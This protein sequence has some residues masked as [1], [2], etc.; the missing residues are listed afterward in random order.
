MAKPNFQGSRGQDGKGSG[1]DRSFVES[2]LHTLD[3][4]ASGIAALAGA[5]S[6]GLGQPFVAAVDLIREA[7]GRVIVTGMGNRATSGARSRRRWRR[8]GRRRFLSTP[9]KPVMAIS[10]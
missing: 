2:A 4:E 10:A 9:A 6:D 5:I 8:P 1:Q 7:K 3:A